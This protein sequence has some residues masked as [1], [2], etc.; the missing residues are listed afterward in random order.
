MVVFLMSWVG[1][2][3]ALATF[4]YPSLVSR[5]CAAAPAPVIVVPFNAMNSTP[6]VFGGG[7]E[8]GGSVTVGDEV[9]VGLTTPPGD[10]ESVGDAAVPSSAK[11]LAR[12]A[13]PTTMSA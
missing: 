12:T 13:S 9:S 1:A 8:V 10:G 2:S 4:V 3:A 11:P 5:S 6:F 7:V